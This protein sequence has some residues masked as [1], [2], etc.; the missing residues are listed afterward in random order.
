M[1]R[2]A[3]FMAIAVLIPV[4]VA[5]LSAISIGTWE[6]F[7]SKSKPSRTE[8]RLYNQTSTPQ[9][10]GRDSGTCSTESNVNPGVFEAHRCFGNRHFP[11]GNHYFTQIYDPCWGYFGDQVVCVDTPWD[12]KGTMFKVKK[13]SG[14]RDRNTR[15]E[16]AIRRSAP[17]ALELSNGERCVFQSGGTYTVGGMRANYFCQHKGEHDFKGARG[18]WVVG[19]PSRSTAVW[20]ALFAESQEARSFKEV[21]V[22]VA[23]Y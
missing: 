4:L 19:T 20:R 8:I 13:W 5:L 7:R 14:F 21:G 6:H 17:W 23:W 11:S 3:R 16:Q 10:A 22:Y 12:R 2:V 15:P 18:G 9:T 1:R